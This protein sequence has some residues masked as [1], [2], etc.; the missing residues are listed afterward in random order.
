M[1]KEGVLKAIKEFNKLRSPEATAELISIK[2]N[3]I[4]VKMSQYIL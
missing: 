3:M 4:I 1:L 2:E